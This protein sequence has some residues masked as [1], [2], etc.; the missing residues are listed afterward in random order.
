M[1]K[2]KVITIT[3]L[4]IIAT[5]L[6]IT[7]FCNKTITNAAKNKLYT[8]VQNI[9]YNR[10]GLLLGTS[11]SGRFG[12]NNLYYDYRIEAAANLIKNKKIKY[13]II[14]G[15]NSR[16]DYN[17]PQSMRTDLINAGIDSSIIYLDYAGFRTFDSIKRL[18]E[19]FSQD[20]V[21]IISQKFHNERAIYLASK[22]G[23]TAIGY[24]AKDVNTAH[25]FKTQCREKL[26]R[27]KVFVD[28]LFGTKPKY[29]GDKINIPS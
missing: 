17:E 9:P 2:R 27:V 20:S 8:D 3:S 15:D 12:H 25:G 29:L 22:E 23:I 18:K 13:L 26:A 19:I 6:L 5:L 14:S 16:K 10:V 7:W 11:K 28:Y 21:T 4:A 24:N 1:R